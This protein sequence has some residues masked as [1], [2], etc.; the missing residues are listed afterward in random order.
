MLDFEYTRRIQIVK[1]IVAVLG[2]T[3]P[4]SIGYSGSLANRTVQPSSDIDLVMII[5]DWHVDA[6]FHHSHF[7]QFFQIYPEARPVREHFAHQQIDVIRASGYYK[8]IRVNCEIYCIDSL[9]RILS[10]S[11]PEIKI[12]RKIPDL[13]F[14]KTKWSATDNSGEAHVF[15][16]IYQKFF[17]SWL[18]TREC[19]Q[20]AENVIALGPDLDRILSAIF[21]Q[22][23]LEIRESVHDCWQKIFAII[24]QSPQF[25]HYAEYSILVKLFFHPPRFIPVNII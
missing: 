5:P 16:G 4:V 24:R 23:P 1:E 18:L 2:A 25:M 22:D 15:N 17:G 20:R 9:E 12:V 7:R 10:L 11:Q 3:Q 6:L 13:R 8:N 14:M 21:E 19:F